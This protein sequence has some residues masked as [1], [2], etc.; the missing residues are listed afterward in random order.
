MGKQKKLALILKLGSRLDHPYFESSRKV[1]HN[2]DRQSCLTP[3]SL[4]QTQSQAA[5]LSVCLFEHRQTREACQP[6]NLSQTR[7]R[8]DD[9]PGLVLAV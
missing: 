9:E 4:L 8:A 7:V 3:S 6:R 5:V 1:A 2:S